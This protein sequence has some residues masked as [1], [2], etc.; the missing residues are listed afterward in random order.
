[1]EGVTGALKEQIKS[2]LV[3]LS[4]AIIAGLAM[5]CLNQ[6]TG[7]VA[8][9]PG[10]GNYDLAAAPVTAN[11]TAQTTITL[12]IAAFGLFGSFAAITALVVLVKAIIG[13]VRGL[14]S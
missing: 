10:L 14:Q 13:V 2:I 12:F 3:M 11:E 5:I 7:V 8:A 1:M 9:M 4:V 6:I